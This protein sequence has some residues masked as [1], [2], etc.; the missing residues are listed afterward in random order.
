MHRLERVLA[1]N[2]NHPG[3]CHLYIHAVEARDPSRALACAERLA[4]LMPG[5]GHLVHMPGHIYIRIGRYTDA[6]ALN[7]HAAHADG[8]M[9]EG[10]GVARRGIYANGYYPHNY[11]FL[12]F[13]A[14][15]A[16]HE[17]EGD[18]RGPRDLEAPRRRSR[19]R[20]AVDRVGH[21]RSC[22]SRS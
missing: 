2:P 14:S 7:E 21:A 18:R 4:A 15:M 17:S 16:G 5:A 6:I 1:A 20:C 10:T 13:A 3:A 11:H 19:A 9:L 8:E 12:S 22:R